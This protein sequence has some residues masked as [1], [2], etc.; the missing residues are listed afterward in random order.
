MSMLKKKS[1]CRSITG[2]LRLAETSAAIWAT[3]CLSRATHSRVPGPRPGGCWRPP[4]VPSPPSLWA[5]ILSRAG[6]ST[7]RWDVQFDFMLL[8]TTLVLQLVLNRPNCLPI[9]PMLPSAF[10]WGS[11]GRQCWKPYWVRVGSIH[12]S[13]AHLPHLSLQIVAQTKGQFCP[14]DVLLRQKYFLIG[15][16]YELTVNSELTVA[17]FPKLSIWQRL[18]Y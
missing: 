16:R 12:C 17:W 8:I 6:P 3:R 10:L 11:H 14:I 7:D 13:S 4:R 15:E 2:W 9:Q 1:S 5:E 18:S